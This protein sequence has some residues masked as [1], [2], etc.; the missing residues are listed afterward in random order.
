MKKI[1]VVLFSLAVSVA[2]LFFGSTAYAEASEARVVAVS[3]SDG[4]Y[5]LSGFDNGVLGEELGRFHSIGELISILDTEIAYVYFNSV[6][7]SEN[8]FI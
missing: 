4:E 1:G 7:V 3:E 5:L 2:M 6:R 8:I